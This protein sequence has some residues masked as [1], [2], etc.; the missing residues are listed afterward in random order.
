MSYH[1]C[2]F[3]K[4]EAVLIDFQ[5]LINL[6]LRLILCLAKKYMHK[7]KKSKEFYKA[8]SQGDCIPV[9]QGQF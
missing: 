9:F 2:H 5:N 1:R 8:Y 6:L 3:C 7:F 4:C